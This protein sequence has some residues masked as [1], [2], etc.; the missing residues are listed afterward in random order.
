MRQF[1]NNFATVRTNKSV[2]LSCKIIPYYMPF[3]RFTFEGKGYQYKVLH[4]GLFLAPHTFIK[5][6]LCS[7][8][9]KLIGRYWH[10]WRLVHYT[11][12]SFEKI[13]LQNKNDSSQLFGIHCSICY[14]VNV[15]ITELYI[16]EL[17]LLNKWNLL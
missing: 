12:L 6:K 5:C 11:M 8:P 1:R 3:L 13:S 9:W 2:L 17:C 16:I 7:L 10:N 15:C 14:M 4:F